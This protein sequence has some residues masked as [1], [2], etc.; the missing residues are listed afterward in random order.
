[1]AHLVRVNSELDAEQ[2]RVD[3]ALAATTPAPSLYEAYVLRRTLDTIAKMRIAVGE[4]EADHIL[5][6]NTLIQTAPA[7]FWSTSFW[8]GISSAIAADTSNGPRGGV[9]RGDP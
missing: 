1:M 6:L 8:S 2:A 7:G 5:R 3:A 4:T 9:G